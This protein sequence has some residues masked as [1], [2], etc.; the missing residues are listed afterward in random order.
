MDAQAEI[1]AQE[2]SELLETDRDEILYYINLLIN[3]AGPYDP[4]AERDGLIIRGS[5]GQAV[6]LHP[7]MAMSNLYRLAVARDKRVRERRARVDELIAKLISISQ[8]R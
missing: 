4:R 5:S 2:I 1:I 7:R 8:K 3:R 6:P